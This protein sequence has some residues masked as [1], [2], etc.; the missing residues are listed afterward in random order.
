MS[1]GGNIKVTCTADG[2]YATFAA[3]DAKRA[4]IVNNTADEIQVQQ[5]GSGEYLPIPS[6]LMMEFFGI[7]DMSDLGVKMKTAAATDVYARWEW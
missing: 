1:K 5:G 6:G 2:N 7:N 4:V 3:Q